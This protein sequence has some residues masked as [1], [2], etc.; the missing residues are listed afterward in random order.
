MV[1]LPTSQTGAGSP[2]PV[3]DALRQGQAAQREIPVVR[4]SKAQYARGESSQQTGECGEGQYL[5]R[6]HAVNQRAGGNNAASESV[7]PA[8]VVGEPER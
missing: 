5:E 3:Q 8:A 4:W 2:R 1:K 7:R 6:S